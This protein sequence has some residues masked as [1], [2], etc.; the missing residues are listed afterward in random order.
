MLIPHPTS[1]PSRPSAEELRL[2]QREV[3]LSFPAYLTYSLPDRIAPRAAASAAFRGHP[4]P[5]EKLAYGEAAF[6]RWLKVEPE[7]YLRWE[8]QWRKGPGARWVAVEGDGSAEGAAAAV[9]ERSAGW[10]EAEE[11]L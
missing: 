2:A 9:G 10:D 8:G 6:V 7:D 11:E 1:P 3:L 4:L 5:L